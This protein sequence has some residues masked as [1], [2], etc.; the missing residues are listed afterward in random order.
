MTQ[1]ARRAK[2]REKWT[3]RTVID[4]SRK[5]LKFRGRINC[6][7]RRRRV[8]L[9]TQSGDERMIVQTNW[10]ERKFDFPF[11]PGHFPCILERVRGTP[12][13]C[14]EML[15]AVP[16]AL[17]AARPGPRSWSMQ[18]HLGH[19]LDLDELHDGRIDDYL[20]G[21]PVLRAA[22]TTNQKTWT[23]N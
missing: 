15:A 23:G 9:G 17:L 11:P 19:L 22:D 10:M 2:E 1:A 16:P 21:R 12:A 6:P 5:V 18:E 20:A 4:V 7:E 13:R 14:R 3:S 8:Y